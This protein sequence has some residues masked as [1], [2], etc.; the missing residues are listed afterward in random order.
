MGE[1]INLKKL[2]GIAVPIILLI[3]SIGV[4]LHYKPYLN[5]K[6]GNMS[7]SLTKE[8]FFFEIENPTDEK[9][10]FPRMKV[11]M[12]ADDI[13]IGEGKTEKKEIPP[14]D[15]IRVPLE[16]KEDKNLTLSSFNKT[17]IKGNVTLP[18]PLLE[19]KES[20]EITKYQNGSARKTIGGK[21]IEK[22]GDLIG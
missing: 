11:K 14:H 22:A 1:G 13:L 7:Y 5:L 20:F 3:S 12:F 2:I 15:K 18:F 6:N 16:M 17:T 8:G 21:K 19:Q 9:M 4:Y 10:K